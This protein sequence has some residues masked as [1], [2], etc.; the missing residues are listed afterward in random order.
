MSAT[1]AIVRTVTAAAFAFAITAGATFVKPQV[2]AA[3]TPPPVAS[4][5]VT[6]DATNGAAHLLYIP[7]PTVKAINATAGTD[8]N[9]IRYWTRYY[10]A[11]TGVVLSDWV[12]GG[13]ASATDT[14]AAPFSQ[15]GVI[16]GSPWSARYALATGSPNVR[17]QY[18]VAWYAT[19]GTV[20]ATSTPYVAS[21]KLVTKTTVYIYGTGYVTVTTTSTVAS[22]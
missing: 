18:F 4:G 2:A 13:V 11:S 17:A 21:Y 15:K 20:L 16:Y 7:A 1:T 14:S 8:K 10:N 9:T 5:T 6:C 19:D 12:L 3:A 22:C